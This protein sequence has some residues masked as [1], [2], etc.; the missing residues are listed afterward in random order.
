MSLWETLLLLLIISVT[1]TAGSVEWGLYLQDWHVTVN[2]N[3]SCK[4][5]PPQ[6]PPCPTAGGSN[7]REACLPF[8]CFCSGCVWNP[9]SL[10]AGENLEVCVICCCWQS[11]LCPSAEDWASSN[12]LNICRICLPVWSQWSCRP[13][14][15]AG[16]FW[17]ADR[18]VT[19]NYIL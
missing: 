10:P 12:I 13:F 8:T 7:R 4:C 6:P 5:C 18:S 2:L 14:W 17:F 19:Q 15:T 1:L 16:F 9:T 3:Y 11:P